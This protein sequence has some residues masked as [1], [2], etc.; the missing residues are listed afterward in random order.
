MMEKGEILF[1]LCLLTVIGQARPVTETGMLYKPSSQTTAVF[2]PQSST[3]VFRP[4]TDTPV[5]KPVTQTEVFH[6]VTSEVVYKPV[7]TVEVERPVTNVNVWRP[8]TTITTY[9]PSN[10]DPVTQ[11]VDFPPTGGVSAKD[12][13][14]TMGGVLSEAKDFKKE[15]EE[16][17]GL[18]LQ[19]D[20]GGLAQ[21][22]DNVSS[23]DSFIDAAKAVMEKY[24]ANGSAAEFK[25]KAG[26]SAPGLLNKIQG[27][28]KD[29]PEKVKD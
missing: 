8:T 3:E 2:H 27:A 21:G 15:Q 26:N 25:E 23:K 19:E 12:A 5:V 18:P 11:Q 29:E 9:R 28:I 7:T 22:L 10:T 4:V 16:K 13:P 17:K 24:D 6:P 20:V 1:C 14:T